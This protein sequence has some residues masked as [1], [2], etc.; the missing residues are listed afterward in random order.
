MAPLLLLNTGT[1]RSNSLSGRCT[2]GTSVSLRAGC[3]CQANHSH[4][5]ESNK[6][7]DVISVFRREED[8]NCALL[9]CYFCEYRQ[10]LSIVLGQP[11]GLIFRG[12]ESKRIQKSS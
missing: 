6:S 2:P 5:R 12:Q 1:K 4:C 9:G 10:F 8:D 11:I 3:G 7:S